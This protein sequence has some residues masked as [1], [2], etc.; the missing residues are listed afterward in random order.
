[1]AYTANAEKS[2]R[3]WGRGVVPEVDTALD[4][5]GLIE[6]YP[7]HWWDSSTWYEVRDLLFEAGFV[8]EAQL[9]QFEAVPELA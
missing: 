3:R 5:S 1:M 9:A 8:K 6:R 2:P 4:K 7:A